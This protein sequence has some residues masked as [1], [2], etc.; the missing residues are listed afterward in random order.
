MIGQ[1][2]RGGVGGQAREERA[3]AKMDDGRKKGKI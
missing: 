2:G 1:K 3:K